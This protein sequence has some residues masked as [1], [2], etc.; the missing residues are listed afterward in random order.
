MAFDEKYTCTIYKNFN[1]KASKLKG[2]TSALASHIQVDHKRS[3]NASIPG[4]ERVQSGLNKF[5]KSKEDIPD[6][7]DT[8]VDW[9]INTCQAFTTSEKPKF[10]AII[11]SIGYTGKII[12]GDTITKYILGRVE[13]SENNLI[14]LLDRTYITITIL[15]DGWTSTNN[16][17]I[18]A[19]NGKW[20]GPDIKIYQACLDFIKIKGTHSCRNLTQIVYKRG[21]KLG[22]LHKIISLTGDNTRNNDT[23]TRHLHKI[24]GYIYDEYLD[25]MPVYNKSI[26]FRGEASKIDYLAYI[27]NLVVKAILKS[28]GSSTH[29]DAIAFLDR[30][31]NNG[32]NK[33]TLPLV[34]GDITILRIIVLWI[35][36]LP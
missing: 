22:I 34:S 31:S 6:F 16:L 33:V 30:I 19:I 4:T 11:R 9:I 5:I 17:S 15:F 35:N 24:I 18:F 32:W 8:I 26:R 29:K 27:D 23:C 36:R 3:E 2:A 10:K 21:K 7:E 28:L 14:A 20:A 25:P 1:R 12:G 13:V